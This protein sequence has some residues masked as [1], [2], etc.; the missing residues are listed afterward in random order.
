MVSRCLWEER[1]RNGGTTDFYGELPRAIIGKG[2]DLAI[3]SQAPT[4]TRLEGNRPDACGFSGAL[5]IAKQ[6]ATS[7]F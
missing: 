7:H 2:V 3:V 5:R 4:P 1:R 6:A